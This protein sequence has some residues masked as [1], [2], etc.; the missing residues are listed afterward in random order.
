MNFISVLTLLSYLL[1]STLNVTKLLF[2][3][4]EIDHSAPT[5]S[6][7]QR[8]GYSPPSYGEQPYPENHFPAYNQEYPSYYNYPPMMQQRGGPGSYHP[9]P[10]QGYGS[11]GGGYGYNSQ[12]AYPPSPEQ[13]G[14]PPYPPY[15]Y[16]SSPSAGPY[17]ASPPYQPMQSS[18]GGAQ[19]QSQPPP[20]NP[21]G[22]F[23]Q[24][25]SQ[26]SSNT[27]GGSQQGYPYHSQYG[28][29]NQGS[30]QSFHQGQQQFMPSMQQQQQGGLVNPDHQH[31]QDHSGYSM[32]DQ[33][34]HHISSGGMQNVSL[35][36]PQAPPNMPPPQQQQ[37]Q[38]GQLTHPGEW[39]YPP[40]QS[41][42]PGDH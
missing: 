4:L 39:V 27:Y 30:R 41:G 37:Q 38:H 40:H 9:Q 36:V 18:S 21:S 10:Q 32:Q 24:S 12:Q 20:M 35:P 17:Q 14:Y 8:E 13:Q 25:Q 26:S 42:S 15:P 2:K 3:W 16:Y 6:R 22:N 11:W 28:A 33:G 5:P 7:T 34:A 23:E 29:S 1:F 19:Y 31:M